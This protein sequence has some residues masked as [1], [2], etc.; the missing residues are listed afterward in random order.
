MINLLPEE[1]KRE[2]R[3]DLNKRLMATLWGVAA[4]SLLSLLFVLLPLDFFILGEI[5]SRKILLKQA[6]N[7]YNQP[8]FVLLGDE[9]DGYNKELGNVSEYYKK[10]V[11]FSNA[12]GIISGIKR[13]DGLYLNSI[14]IERVEGKN[15]KVVL[16]GFGKSREDVLEFKDSITSQKEV[17][18]VLFSPSSWIK[19]KNTDFLLTCKITQDEI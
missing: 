19:A 11:Y 12:L 17:S 15:M 7:N 2:L 14:S 16:T 18:E 8:D 10:H 6:E 9:I 5:G 4:V 3:V 1:Q 13:P